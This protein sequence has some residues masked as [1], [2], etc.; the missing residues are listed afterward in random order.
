M[1]S[2]T[3]YSI[4]E[5]RKL[6]G[7]ISRNTIYQLLNSRRLASV[8][9]GGRRFISANAI[10]DLIEQS[11]TTQSP[12]QATVRRSNSPKQ[13]TLPFRSPSSLRARTVRGHG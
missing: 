11:T 5:S 8:V 6:L 13:I 12:S 10:A 3:L 4:Q 7:G 2:H 9:I 1:Q